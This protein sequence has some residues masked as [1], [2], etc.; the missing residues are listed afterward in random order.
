[1]DPILWICIF[2]PLIVVL[3][4]QQSRKKSAK[5]HRVLHRIRAN[6]KGDGLTMNE[7]L[8]QFVGKDCII[9]TMNETIT[10]TLET[11]EDRWLV[12][13]PLNSR[14]AG[15]EIIQLDY[16]SRVREYPKGRNGRNKSVVV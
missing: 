9:T 14:N 15:K 13:A 7:I 16:I 10:G 1:M 6:M 4:E 8:K 5:Q 12:I 2:L 3:F 11:V